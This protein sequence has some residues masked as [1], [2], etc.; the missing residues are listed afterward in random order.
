MSAPQGGR[1]PI[2]GAPP[3]GRGHPPADPFGSHLRRSRDWTGGPRARGDRSCGAAFGSTQQC[4][5]ERCR[6]I[7]HAA[8]RPISQQFGRL[9]LR[10]RAPPHPRR[11]AAGTGS[12]PTTSSGGVAGW[13][14]G[15]E[16]AR[17]RCDRRRRHELRRRRQ[18][19]A[20]DRGRRRERFGEVRVPDAR[21]SAVR[22]HAVEMA[23]TVTV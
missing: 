9:R 1:G 20:L 19:D 8:I 11:Q 7:V 13:G 6:R 17:E 2:P 21:C 5:A 14:E 12:A 15:Q 4:G 3:R 23:V 16:A 22:S 10:R 18:G